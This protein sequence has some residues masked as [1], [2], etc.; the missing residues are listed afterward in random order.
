[1]L[2]KTFEY[3]GATIT[4]RTE[5]GNAYIDRMSADN[6]LGIYETHD[7]DDPKKGYVKGERKLSQ[8][9]AT[10]R[11]QFAAA[12][13]QSE[14]KGD[15]GFKWPDSPVDADEMLAACEAWLALPGSV[16]GQW[17]NAVFMVNV[18]PNDPDLKPPDDVD[19]KD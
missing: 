8:R 18:A 15:L 1:M 3:N 19:P 2:T 6:V 9:I 17:M 7:E 11:T 5:D 10:R 14:I 13:V 12:Y 4:V 16:V